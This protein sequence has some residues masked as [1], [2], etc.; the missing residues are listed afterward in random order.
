MVFNEITETEYNYPTTLGEMVTDLTQQSHTGETNILRI[1][2][3]STPHGTR[4]TIRHDSGAVANP[5]PTAHRRE[6]K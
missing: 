2:P 5:S 1:L 3:T 4:H 6:Y